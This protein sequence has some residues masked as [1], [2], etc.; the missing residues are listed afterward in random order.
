MKNH[1]ETRN[2]GSTQAEFEKMEF[3]NLEHLTK[4]FDRTGSTS[5]FKQL[6]DQ[7]RNHQ[8]TP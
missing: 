2:N 4:L 6:T 5:G 3:P 1:T 7:N 8:R